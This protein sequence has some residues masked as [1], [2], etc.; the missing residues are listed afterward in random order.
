MEIMRVR[1]VCLFASFLFGF[2]SCGNDV[3]E[4][5]RQPGVIFTAEMLN[6]SDK[7]R[8]HG[9][10]WESGDQIGVFVKS[11]GAAL[12]A[13]S[14]KYTNVVYQTTG[15]GVFTATA[16]PIEYP[17][18]NSNVDVIAYYP[19]TTSLNG[20]MYEVNV[21]DQSIS[22]KID[23]VWSHNITATSAE[24]PQTGMRFAHQLAKICFNIKTG[25]NPTNLQGLTVSVAGL[26][27]QAKFNLG[28]GTF[29]VD[30]TSAKEIAFNT[31]ISSETALAEALVIPEDARAGRKVS[32]TM[33]GGEQFEWEIPSTTKLERGGSYTWSITLDGKAASAT[34]VSGYVE[35]PEMTNIPAQ[36]TYIEHKMP[37]GDRKH[38]NYAMLYDRDLKMAYWVAYPLHPSHMIS[39]GNRTDAWAYDPAISSSAQPYLKKGIGSVYDRGHQL[40]SADRNASVDLN[41]TTFYYT[42]M[43]AQEKDFNQQIWRRLEEKIR[44]WV[45]QDTLYVVTGAMP[46]TATDQAVKYVNDNNGQ[47]MAVPK[48]HF[49]A[50][51]KRSGGTYYTLA[52]KMD[53]DNSLAT[54]QYNNYRL[55]VAELEKITGFKFF[56]QIP[57]AAK[58]TIDASKW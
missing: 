10:T 18:D 41:R 48:Y 37:T 4:D 15:N 43:T 39:G 45:T 42:N 32:F 28:D 31:T 58:N 53:N 16:K 34:A 54:G 20:Y 6:K 24:N 57:A 1:N 46:T 21:Q 51:A 17:K 7:T 26:P 3:V 49:K 47:P 5:V 27:T 29:T 56:P 13:S 52:F 36:A 30:G 8:A 9:T 25:G 11:S 33:P 12:S 19:H 38:R 35:T 40:P 50:L 2:Y 22:K 23:L 14:V 44:T 55:T